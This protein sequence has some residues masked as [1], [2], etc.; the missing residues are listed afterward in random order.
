MRALNM[1][2]STGHPK[3]KLNLRYLNF[4]IVTHI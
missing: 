1:M 4:A 3:L 2:D